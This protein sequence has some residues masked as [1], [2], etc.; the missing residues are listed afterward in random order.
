[1]EN[2]SL[3]IEDL[4]EK[5]KEEYIKLNCYNRRLNRIRFDQF[6]DSKTW[7]AQREWGLIYPIDKI[8]MI[9]ETLKLMSFVKDD[10]EQIKEE[11]FN[12][13]VEANPQIKNLSALEKLNIDAKLLLC[14]LFDRKPMLLQEEYNSDT[15][16]S[17]VIKAILR[18]CVSQD[19]PLQGLDYFLNVDENLKKL[20][21]FLNIDEIRSEIKNSNSFY[22]KFLTKYIADPSVFSSFYGDIES[23]FF[24]VSDDETDHDILEDDSESK[25]K[26]VHY[27][28]SYDLDYIYFFVDGSI[29]KTPVS[30]YQQFSKLVFEGDYLSQCL[31]PCDERDLFYNGYIVGEIISDRVCKKRCINIAVDILKHGIGKSKD[32]DIDEEIIWNKLFNVD[33]RIDENVQKRLNME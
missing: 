33:A 18:D 30:F 4:K 16:Y 32:Y 21:S 13:F 12:L 5:I 11:M 27:F 24:D 26:L 23:L 15:I 6:Y 1:M 7:E 25:E 22:R 9:D 14:E 19:E 2:V 3:K 29:Q 28:D 17:I 8:N 20:D 31:Y 10:I